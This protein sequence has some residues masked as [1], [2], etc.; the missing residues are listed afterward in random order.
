MV[1][2]VESLPSKSRI[3]RFQLDSTLGRG[4][5]GITYRATDT[6]LGRT[7]AIKEFLPGALAVRHGAV[8]V[9]PR[10]TKHAEEFL[11]GRADFLSEGRTLARMPPAPGIVRVFD[12]L[13]ANGTAYIVME[14]IQGM[15]LER[16]LGRGPIDAALLNSIL[17]PLL[18]GLEV[19]HKTGFLHRDIKP[20]NI[21]I[22]DEGAPV[23]VDFG[24]ARAAIGAAAGKITAVLTPDYAAIE[25]FTASTQGPWT[26]IYGLAATLYH[27]LTGK[28]A[29]NA[30]HRLSHDGC[31]PLAQLS[32]PGIP[33]SLLRGIDAGMAVH[34]GDRPRSIA[35]W[36]R[37]LFDGGSYARTT[38]MPRRGGRT[39]I[40]STPSNPARASK[41]RPPWTRKNLLRGGIAAAAAVLV[42]SAIVYWALPSGQRGILGQPEN[43][44]RMGTVGTRAP[45]MSGPATAGPSASAARPVQPA[46]EGPTDGRF[47]GNLTVSLR[48]TPLATLVVSARI[49]G[50]SFTG[51]V[52]DPRCGL[53][54]IRLATGRTGDIIGNTAF[55]LPNCKDTIATGA[56]VLSERGVFLSLRAEQ[57]DIEGLLRRV[58]D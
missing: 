46:P 6:T 43:M 22:N 15:T 27:A 54:R 55:L 53:F 47:R 42:L 41:P 52:Q 19:V 7:V 50:S 56:G 49:E 16:R 28:M 38:P 2:N 57:H 10:S 36:R 45:A 34:P 26:D 17:P 31:V 29:P 40:P 24:A 32:P 48:G 9:L 35:D 4:T 58:Q 23:L 3:G 11:R 13:E 33:R 18:Q 8:A 20:A 37:V 30:T 21:L 51:E 12:F 39:T 44:A 1:D 5:F 25:Q 14:F